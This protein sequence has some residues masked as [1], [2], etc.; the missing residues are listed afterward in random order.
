MAQPPELVEM[1]A[2]ID[3]AR[4]QYRESIAAELEQLVALRERFALAI[5]EISAAQALEGWRRAA[6]EYLYRP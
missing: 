3:R 4:G 5:G 6:I 2:L 1:R